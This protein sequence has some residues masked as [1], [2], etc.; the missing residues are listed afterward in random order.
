MFFVSAQTVKL[1]ENQ[2]QLFG[3][4]MKQQLVSSLKHWFG[5][6]S[7]LDHQLPVMEAVLS[8]KD[9]CVVMPTGA[10]KSLC[11]QLPLLMRNR[12][13]IIVSPLIS[14]MKDQVD[15]LTDRNI[16]AAYINTTVSPAAQ[17]SILRQ[18]ENGLLKL[19][20]VAPERFQTPGFRDFIRANPPEA[21]IIDEAHC[22]SQWGHDFRPSY[23]K[24]GVIA[25]ELRI[26]Q[27]CAFTATATKTVQKDIVLQLRR[28][29]MEM[30]VA[31]FKRPNL[32]FSVIEAHDATSKNHVIA[33]LLENYH[34]PVI[35]YAST[36]K[37]VESLRKEFGC[38]AYHGGMSDQERTLAQE[39][40]MNETSPVLA[41]TN[42]FGMG[43]DRPDVRRV[44]HYNLPGSIEAYYQ[45]AGRAGRDGEP[46]ECILISGNQD[47]FI[48]HFLIEMN[49]PEPQ[50]VH[51]LYAFLQN[52]WKKSGGLP[53]EMTLTEIAEQIPSAK[54][55]STVGAAFAILE[56]NGYVL[57]TYSREN[58][59]HF[60]ISDDLEKV[61]KEN[62]QEKTQ[63]ARFLS[64]V[65]QKYGA[66][67]AV[68]RKY[69]LT[70]LAELC[71]L[72]QENIKRILAALDGKTLSVKKD[73]FRGAVTTLLKPEEKKLHIDF[74]QYDRKRELEMERLEDMISYTKTNGCKQRFLISYFGEESSGWECG[75]CDHCSKTDLPG[76]RELDAA[77]SAT[78]HTILSSVRM[79]NGKLGRGKLSQILAGMLNA[80]IAGSRYAESACFGI[81]KPMK[82]T[83]IMQYLRELEKKGFL[84]RCGNPEYPCLGISEK[85]ENQLRERNVISLCI[86]EKKAKRAT[87]TNMDRKE[88]SPQEQLNS[89]LLARLK[90]LR[91]KLASKRGVPSYIIFGDK[92]LVEFVLQKPVTVD[93]AK[94]I[95]G[96]G[97]AKL[98]TYVPVFV[99]EISQFLN[100]K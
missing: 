7:F 76:E 84:N 26:P 18:V 62:E 41:A 97:P 14:L 75:V 34:H 29:N 9:L 32:A 55:D 52:H 100:E 8:G 1:P 24:L 80:D 69:L 72:P 45:E 2:E 27:V 46:A 61:K 36:R 48:H 90:L 95:P 6:E 89:M 91:A 79:F 87:E 51:A 60:M 96:I 42:A 59:V 33:K 77:E 67:S 30:I 54:T 13:S 25:E 98:A 86:P 66:E 73:L 88:T 19:L 31:G 4:I 38:I 28:E 58:S 53:L 85:G 49:N 56:E 22:I 74:E 63:R 78:V 35:I 15:A 23:M 93:D 11:Y 92:T 50:I 82:Q 3:K 17:Y 39:Q 94:K 71:E 37:A 44:I 20:Y 10:G 99:R 21:L 83:Q 43:I 64:R 65:I 12:Y 70:D 16:P 81:L 40:F 47:R 57:R 68:M 5:Y